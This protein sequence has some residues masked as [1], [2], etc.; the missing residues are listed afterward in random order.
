[1][2]T[3]KIYSI[4]ALIDFLNETKGTNIEKYYVSIEPLDSNT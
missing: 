3:P 4:N 1:M 2:R